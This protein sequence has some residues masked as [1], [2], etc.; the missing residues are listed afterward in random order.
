MGL[1]AGALLD[2]L[3]QAA[4]CL[5]PAQA[6]RFFRHRIRYEEYYLRRI[7][8]EYGAYAARTPTWI[9]FIK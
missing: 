4:V 3:P 6:W 8:P 2:A 5:V 1:D 9:P 7:F